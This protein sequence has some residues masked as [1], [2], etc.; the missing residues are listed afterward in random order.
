MQGQPCRP[1]NQMEYGT[2]FDRNHFL[3][4]SLSIE[5]IG[6]DS[7]V[8]NCNSATIQQMLALISVIRTHKSI[9][10]KRNGKEFIAGALVM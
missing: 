5:R 8:R 10:I 9:V 2:R 3:D 6:N 4:A 1:I 7:H